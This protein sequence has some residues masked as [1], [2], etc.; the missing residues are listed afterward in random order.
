MIGKSTEFL[1]DTAAEFSILKIDKVRHDIYVNEEEAIK[2]KG[3][4]YE[5]LKGFCTSRADLIISGRILNHDFQL[6]KECEDSEYDGILG[7]DFI[8][9][10]RC[11]IAFNEMG[12]SILRFMN[13]NL[14]IENKE[15]LDFQKLPSKY[16]PIPGVNEIK[17]S[18]PLITRS[19]HSVGKDHSDQINKS[20]DKLL[21]NSKVRTRRVCKRCFARS[22]VKRDCYSKFDMNAESNCIPDLKVIQ[23]N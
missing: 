12:K 4:Y 15:K 3:N 8:Q 7:R 20:K 2:I 18:N 16:F 17:T 5:S 19:T 11:Y 13:D 14:E 21:K 6:V 1:I 10:Y 9:K 23:R 22:H